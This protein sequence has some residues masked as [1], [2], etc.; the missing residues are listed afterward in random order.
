MGLL[1][2]ES[3]LHFEAFNCEINT[4]ALQSYRSRV[5]RRNVYFSRSISREC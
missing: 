2:S 5:L 4:R 1:S 3:R